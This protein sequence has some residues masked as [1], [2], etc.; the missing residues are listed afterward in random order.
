MSMARGPINPYAI[1]SLLFI[2]SGCAQLDRFDQRA[3][4]EQVI[5]SELYFGR[6][7]PTGGEV[8]DEQFQQ[9]L[10]EI[11]TPR[12]PDGLSVMEAS[13]QWQGRDGRIVRE[14]SK[15]LLIYHP[16]DGP[17]QRKVHEI[18]DEYARRYGQ[19]SVMRVTTKAW[20]RF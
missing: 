18:A 8:S 7:L 16:A 3:A 9:F 19:D 20:V 6:D 17:S 5:R 14:R 15:M 11:V 4:G 12:F 1:L 10:A 2:L 13:G